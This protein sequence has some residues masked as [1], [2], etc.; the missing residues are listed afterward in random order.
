MQSLIHIYASVY[1]VQFCFLI[2][3]ENSSSERSSV[4][5]RRIFLQKNR[6]ALVYVMA[7]DEL[8]Y[9]WKLISILRFTVHRAEIGL[10]YYGYCVPG[11]R[12][13]SAG[14]WIANW[15]RSLAPPGL[16]I[17]NT[18]NVGVRGGGKFKNRYNERCNRGSSLAVSVLRNN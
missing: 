13:K 10:F 12:N 17:M 1:T 2:E 15:N 18:Y 5:L 6:R 11:K 7:A 16:S 8:E 3:W 4:I 14:F 9:E